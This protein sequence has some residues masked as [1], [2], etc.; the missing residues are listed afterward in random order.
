M[1]IPQCITT[2]FSFHLTCSTLFI[3]NT[4][5]TQSRGTRYHRRCGGPSFVPA[6]ETPSEGRC[7]VPVRVCDGVEEFQRKRC[8][9]SVSTVTLS[10]PGSFCKALHLTTLR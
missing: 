1:Y 4:A 7:G 8:N 3:P 2:L 9:F 5:R 10:G 6:P